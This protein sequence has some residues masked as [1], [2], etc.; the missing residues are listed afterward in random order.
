MKLA[1][2]LEVYILYHFTSIGFEAVIDIVQVNAR[3]G[4]DHSIEDTRWKGLR[5]G[6]EAWKLPT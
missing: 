1:I 6:V 3:H 4:A 5:N 2:E